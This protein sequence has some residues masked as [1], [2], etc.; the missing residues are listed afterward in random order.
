[1]TAHEHLEPGA[2]PPPAAA[3]PAEAIS[4]QDDPRRSPPAPWSPWTAPLALAGGILLAFVGAFAVYL[5]ALALGANVT[6]SHIPAGVTIADTFVQ[7]VAFVM[8]AV[9][10][11]RLGGRAVRSWQ[12]GLRPPAI[13]WR[14]A[15]LT[16]VCLLVAFI[17]LDAIWAE[18]L[19]PTKEKL[20]ETLGTNESSSL[21]V[22]SAALTCIVAPIGE[23][24]LFRG[25]MFTALRNWRGSLPAA[26]IDGLLF[27]AVHVASAPIAD[28]VPLAAL[29]FGLCL[30]YRYTGS[31]YPGIV[32]HSLNNSLAFASLAGW[33]A[34]EG[35]ALIVGSVAGV[36]LVI[37]ACKR[38]GL[39]ADGTGVR[40]A[41]A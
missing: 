24:M 32:A 3:G 4:P 22:L 34:S 29:G 31:L 9:Y 41:A 5:P 13:G 39:I 38:A 30:L 11:A 40:R 33:N 28:L 1:V 37:G 6:G 35:L 19:H 14:W 10:F 8:V 12:F 26:I 17:A 27:G 36:G 16:V 15:A 25:Y 7:D 21:L 2:P 23:E 20:L 18:L